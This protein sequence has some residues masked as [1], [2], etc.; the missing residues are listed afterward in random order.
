MTTTMII[1][2]IIGVFY[3]LG[4]LFQAISIGLK[5]DFNF[6]EIIVFY[7]IML[8]VGVYI[9]T[10]TWLKNM[11]G[12]AE[13]PKPK[14]RTYTLNEN[15][16]PYYRAKIK[17]LGFEDAPYRISVDNISYSGFVYREGREPWI[18]IAIDKIKK[19]TNLRVSI[20][21]GGPRPR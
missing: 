3:A 21:R 15:T 7:L 5:E 4:T 12:V 19:D 11:V 13:N 1:L 20:Y 18:I 9:M 2:I 14:C 17:A 8:I 10:L 16:S 6:F